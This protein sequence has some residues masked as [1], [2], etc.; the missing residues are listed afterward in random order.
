MK[1]YTDEQHAAKLAEMCNRDHFSQST[2]PFFMV[3]ALINDEC[4]LT[5][6]TC[7]DITPGDWLEYLRQHRP[8]CTK[9]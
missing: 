6:P 9:A 5:K 4:S 1:Q 3:G 2:C 8:S 7:K